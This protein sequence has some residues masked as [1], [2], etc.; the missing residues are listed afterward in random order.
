MNEAKEAL[1]KIERLVAA[2]PFIDG[3]RHELMEMIRDYG[4]AEY[5]QGYDNALDAEEE[6]S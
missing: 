6:W 5:T 2:F 3:L 1:E 4:E